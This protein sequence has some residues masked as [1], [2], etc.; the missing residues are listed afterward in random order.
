MVCCFEMFAV[1]A[2]WNCVVIFALWLVVR[3]TIFVKGNT[4]ITRILIGLLKRI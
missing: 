3:S 2:S 4:N 1:H